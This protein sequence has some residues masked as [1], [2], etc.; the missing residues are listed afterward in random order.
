MA[1]RDADST[2]QDI[3]LK[4]FEAGHTFMAADSF[5]ARV[6]KQFRKKK[7]IFDFN[8]YV[9]CVRE[10]GIAIEL[11]PGDFFDWKNGLSQ[12]KTSKESRPLLEEVSVVQFRV[13]E[14]C[15]YFKRSFEE[16]Y[17]CADFLMKR[18]KD[19]VA[20]KRFFT[21][22]VVKE[23]PTIDSARKQ[24]IINKLCPFMPTDRKEFWYNL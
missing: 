18:F 21:S 10:A 2:P 17:K 6:E 8:D 19:L 20:E 4:Y 9:S 12:G 13:G 23:R 16:D 14:A 7:N 5:H 1:E 3:T 24:G 22:Q 11:L 15:M